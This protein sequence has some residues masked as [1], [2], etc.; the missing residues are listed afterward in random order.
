MSQASIPWQGRSFSYVHSVI[1]TQRHE[2]ELCGHGVVLKVK[3]LFRN[4]IFV[5]W[6]AMPYWLQ[7]WE[8]RLAIF[9][10]IFHSLMDTL[11]SMAMQQR[12][13][14]LTSMPSPDLPIPTVAKTKFKSQ[15]S[16]KI[17]GV[18]FKVFRYWGTRSLPSFSSLLFSVRFKVQNLIG[19]IH[20]LP[21][22]DGMSIQDPHQHLLTQVCFEMFQVIPQ[23]LR[24]SSTSKVSMHPWSD[25]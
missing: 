4:L 23:K 5:N 17:L 16:C 24:V 7:K 9:S 12:R 25:V 20:F 11:I 2:A 14:T 1:F 8:R 6:F 15:G 10:F 19:K 3:L 18:L 13:G 22:Q 21:T